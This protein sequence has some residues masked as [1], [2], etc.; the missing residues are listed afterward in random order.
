MVSD[1]GRGYATCL[2]QFVNHSTRL[3]EQVTLWREM[4]VKESETPDGR[5]LFDD[6]SAV[7]SWANGA[8][9][10]LYELVKPRRGVPIIEWRRAKATA[11]RAINIGHGFE[12][13]S[14]SNPAEAMALLDAAASCLIDLERRGYA[15]QTLDQAMD[16]DTRLGLKPD[17]GTW[18]CTEDIE[19]TRR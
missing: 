10:H 6:A 12:P 11:D 16:T 7:E 3:S 18:S 9:D 1:F 5:P 4:R 2:R 14:K 17:A 19:R 8:S 15:V 13:S